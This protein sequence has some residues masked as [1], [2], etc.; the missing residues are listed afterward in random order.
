[1]TDTRDEAVAVTK[2]YDALKA[3]DLE[4]SA[5]SW[6][7]F[8]LFGSKAS[9]DEAN[10]L[11]HV[12]STADQFREQIATL[13]HQ[14]AEAQTLCKQRLD[15]LTFVRSERDKLFHQLAEAQEVIERQR[16]VTDEMIAAGS[17]AIDDYYNGT[18]DAPFEGSVKACYLAMYSAA[19][20]TKDER[21]YNPNVAP[22]D[23][24]EFGMKP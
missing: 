10:R 2:F 24:A 13:T 20:G 11:L 8:N 15:S 19:M 7:G 14:L 9:I 21:E 16:I 4:H 12:A 18:K 1:M 3:A 22:C 6:G 17:Q 23:D 5:M